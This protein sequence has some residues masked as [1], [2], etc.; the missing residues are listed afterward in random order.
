MCGCIRGIRTPAV[1]GQVFEPAG[2]SVAIHPGAE[3][4]AQDRPL[5]ASVDGAVDGSGH[6]GWQ[7]DQ[8]DRAALAADTQDPVA[9]L[10]AQVGD[11]GAARFEDA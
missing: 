6:R 1:G 7:R 5:R 8:D 2:G 11:A 10:L 9:V 4:V 3:G